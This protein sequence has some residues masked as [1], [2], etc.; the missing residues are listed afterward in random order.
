MWAFGLLG[1]LQPACEHTAIDDVVQGI[2][3]ERHDNCGAPKFEAVH[4]RDQDEVLDQVDNRERIHDLRGWRSGL[5]H[6][7]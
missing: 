2:K 7:G 1:M 6:M 5:A 4:K 3:A